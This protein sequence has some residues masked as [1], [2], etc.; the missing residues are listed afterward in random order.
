MK[1]QVLV[2][3]GSW[4]SSISMSLTCLNADVRI[5]R[6]QDNPFELYQRSTHILIPGGADIHPFYYNAPIRFSHP[7][8]PVRDSIEY[9]LVSLALADAKPLMGICRGHQ[10][11]CA[12]AGGTLYQD[13]WHETGINHSRDEHRI[14]LV[15]RSN[16][17]QL[18]RTR[19][20]KVN[21]YHHQAVHDVPAGWRVAATCDGLIEAIEHPRL[22]VISVQWHPEMM[23]D[24]FSDRL[25]AA[26]LAQR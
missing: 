8:D 5:L 25:F 9:G 23:Q 24:R 21:S 18:M 13:I 2:T 15:R 16:L 4:L 22:P 1:P 19:S 7:G 12:V 26:F 3:Q 10:M 11:I 17:Y 20:Y 6:R 14:T